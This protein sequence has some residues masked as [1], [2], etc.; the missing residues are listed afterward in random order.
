MQDVLTFTTSFGTFANTR[1]VFGLKVAASIFQALVDLLIDG[2]N[3]SGITGLYAYPDDIVIGAHSF[4]EMHNKSRSLL[5]ILIKYNLMIFWKKE[6][7]G[8]YAPFRCGRFE[9]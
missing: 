7:N 1:L 2:L 8:K 6:K 5:D 4:Q 9:L 3:L